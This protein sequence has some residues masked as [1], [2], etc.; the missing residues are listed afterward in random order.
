MVNG[1]WYTH[2]L[3]S[4]SLSCFWRCKEYPCPLSPDWRF[5][6]PLW[7]LFGILHNE[8]DSDRVIVF[9]TLMFPILAVYLESES[10]R[11]FNVLHIMIEALKEAK[12]YWVGYGILILIWIMSMVFDTIIFQIF[13]LYVEFKGANNVHVPKGLIGAVEDSGGFSYGSGILTMM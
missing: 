7:F 10:T 6:G 11:N 5:E 4:G 3:K 13:A 8:Y 9:D 1:L 12:N 2:V